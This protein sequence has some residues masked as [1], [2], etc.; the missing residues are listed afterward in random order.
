MFLKIWGVQ[1]AKVLK[2]G[3]SREDFNY[4]NSF[5]ISIECEDRGFEYHVH[6]LQTLHEDS[7]MTQGIGW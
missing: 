1:R 6:Y 2:F 7:E 3:E 4:F 5:Q